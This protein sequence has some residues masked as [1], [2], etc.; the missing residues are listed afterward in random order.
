LTFKTKIEDA[1]RSGVRRIR[2]F[3]YPPPP[4]PSDG[5]SVPVRPRVGVALGGGFARGLAHVGVLRVLV[6]SGIPIDALAGTS[7][8]SVAA[9]AFAS[10]VPVEQM[11]E[12][13]RKIRWKSFARWT[14]PRLGFASNDRME[15]MLRR[16]LR[17][18]RFEELRIPLAVV[19]ADI[20]TG[21]AVVFRHGD[22]IP[23]LR[24]SCSFPGLFTPVPYEGRLLVDGA[25]VETVPAEALA[26]FGVDTVIAVDLKT[27]GAGHVPT[28]IFQV[29]GQAFQIAQHLNQAPWR[30]H[31]DLVIEPEVSDFRWDDFVRADELIAVGEYATRQALPAVRALLKPRKVPVPRP[32]PAR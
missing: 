21:E 1:L 4:V 14:I 17:C 20:S 11:A 12:E 23:P 13:A 26:D 18:T 3:A 8:G 6:E 32:V 25:I 31:C 2:E 22:L 28:N 16:V 29:V 19:A 30:E 24:A 9:A 15:T 7:V 10:G 27:N 5:E